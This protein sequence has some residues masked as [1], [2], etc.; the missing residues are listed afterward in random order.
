[1]SERFDDRHFDT[2]DE[3]RQAVWTALE[4]EGAAR[5]PKEAVS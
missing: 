3:A 2:K 4:K 1:M 5:F